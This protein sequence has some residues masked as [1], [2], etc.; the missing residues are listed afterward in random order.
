MTHNID[1]AII[2]KKMIEALI[3]IQEY[4]AEIISPIEAEMENIISDE[5]S[6]DVRKR[7]SDLLMIKRLLTDLAKI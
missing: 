2:N 4:G 3:T 1:G 5:S 6:T 7:L